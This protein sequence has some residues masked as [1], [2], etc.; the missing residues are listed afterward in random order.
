M[1]PIF[2]SLLTAVP[3][4]AAEGKAARVD[5]L[6]DPLP[7]GAVARLGTLRLRQWGLLGADFSPDGKMVASA[8]SGLHVRQ[9]DAASGREIPRIA[10]APTGP[11]L[12]VKFSP[13]GRILAA[14][15]YGRYPGLF[16]W[17]A[18]TGKLLHSLQAGG[19]ASLLDMAFA[20]GGK[21][22]LCV[23]NEGRVR[24]WNV[25][26]GARLR[27]W[28]VRESIK[29]PP[30]SWLLAELEPASLTPDGRVLAALV[31]WANDDEKA[32]EKH[33]H[34]L[35]VW[36]LDRRKLRWQLEWKE[37]D[38]SALGISADGKVVAVG[39]GKADISLRDGATGRELRRLTDEEEGGN[40]W[41]SL[42]LS[43]DGK[44]LAALGQ[45]PAGVR[46]WDTQSGKIV[47][48]LGREIVFEPRNRF[49][50][51]LFS[52]DGKRLLF[53]WDDTLALRDVDT[54][55]ERPRLPGHREAVHFL[56]FSDDGRT[57]VSGSESAGPAWA[58]PR[59]A[60]TWDTTKWCEVARSQ[61]VPV[62]GLEF[63][64]RDHRLA[65]VSEHGDFFLTLQPGG[66][67]LRKLAI[68]YHRLHA[69]GGFFSPSGRIAVQPIGKTYKPDPD[70]VVVD[71]ATGKHRGTLPE[72]AVQVFLAFAPDDRT[73]A[74]VDT[75]A[76][77]HVVAVEKARELCR[78][79]RLRSAWNYRSRRPILAFSPAGPQ[80]AFWE[81]ASDAIVF[82]DWQAGRERGR[83]QGDKPLAAL[84][85]KA[86]LAP[87]LAALAYSP[88]GRM[89]ASAGMD[90]SSGVELWEVASGQ[91]R[92]RIG[93]QLGRVFALAFSPDGRL[94][95][96]GSDDTTV[97]VW[98]LCGPSF[99]G[100][101]A[102]PEALWA[103][104]A[105]AD[106]GKAYEAMTTLVEQPATAV[107]LLGQKVQPASVGG[108]GKVA[109]LIADL[110]DGDFDRREQA[111]RALEDLE[112]RA[113]P[114]LRKGLKDSTSPEARRRIERLLDGLRRP[115]PRRLRVLRAVEVLEQLRTPEAR[116][117]LRR[118]AE[119]APDARLTRE[120]Q[121]SLQRLER[122]DGQGLK[123]RTG[124]GRAREE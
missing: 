85:G 93:R 14:G 52:P 104:L 50:R 12:G 7:P 3:T 65:V 87:C 33:Q 13:T 1:G 90:G 37:S 51:P 98:D 67:R 111:T 10:P 108:D 107:S 117:L 123:Q 99:R 78:L 47:H 109:Q 8:G 62:P 100:K 72:A 89:L 77:V 11:L 38:C 83:V 36:D 81:R 115:P 31:W 43:P 88:D 75:E 80:L 61:D 19:E 68:P 91:R 112:E 101:P 55:A 22:L 4:S 106:A 60:I 92:R 124:P 64:S 76:V 105:H 110:D 86:V 71:V 49:C 58:Y 120:A 5:A 40:S 9:W 103:G 34:R 69:T 63:R 57:L 46:V 6:G 29:T 26:D 32:A 59:E 16:L 74:W 116:Q 41:E 82:W 30:G 27:Q 18:A 17:D 44:L 121:A 2:L 97:L 94:L 48:Q 96:S 95:A 42:A 28:D 23:D 102:Q 39:V 25:A 45:G 15:S 84:H 56:A 24:W 70:F 79:G 119:G 54:W 20:D 53:P 122:A 118:L 114:M 113:G 73:L 66:E 21:S 35:T